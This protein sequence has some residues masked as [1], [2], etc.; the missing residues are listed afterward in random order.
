MKKLTLV[1]MIAALGVL[2][3]LP[4]FAACTGDCQGNCPGGDPGYHRD[5]IFKK[6]NLSD[7]QKTKVEALISENQKAVRPLR[8]KMFDKSVELRR[9]WLQANPD[10]DKITA[11]QKELR[12]LRDKKEDRATAL[13]FE[14]RKV[15]TPEQ[16]E[17]LAN[18]RWDRG[19]GF[20]PRGGMRG[21]EEHGSG[22][23]NCQ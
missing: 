12:T 3:T 6:L 22:M 1:L 13:R 23:G 16:N 17:K 10:K 21:H 15:L 2:L 19:P 20:G 7:E 14:I 18:S 9:L 5:K 8:E 4:A 11:V